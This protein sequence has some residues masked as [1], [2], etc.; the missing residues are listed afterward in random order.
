MDS[1]L[2]NPDT[3]FS[4]ALVIL[5]VIFLIIFVIEAVL[6]I[7]AFGFFWNNYEGVQ[8]YILNGWNLLD[9][10]VVVISLV[11]TYYTYI[12]H[13]NSA[14][15][16]SSI[17]ALRAVRALRPLRMISRNKGLRIAIQA[18]FTSIPAMANVLLI[19]LLFILIFAILGVNFFKGTY[20]YCQVPDNNSADEI[21]DWRNCLDTG[22]TWVRRGANFDNV[23]IA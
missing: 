5:D 3:D 19:C 15:D 4:K 2:N 7:I 17:K 12:S 23:L 18:L 21:I 20:Y 14:Q 22:G 8:P 10:T 9:F 6:K 13:S 11:D 1:P 16:L